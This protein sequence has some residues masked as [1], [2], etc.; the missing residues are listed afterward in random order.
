M[1][2]FEDKVVIVTGGN[3][4]IGLATAKM[5]ADEGAKVAITGRSSDKLS[6][7]KSEIGQE[8][9][10]DSVDITSVTE[11]EAFVE[12]VAREHGRID[13][14]VASA[15]GVE[16]RP[17]E[18][19]DESRFDQDLDRNFK[20]AYFTAQRALPHMTQGGSF[21]FLGSAAGSKG[22]EGMT[23]YGPSK[24]AL[25]GLVRSLASELAPKNIRANVVSPGPIPTPG[26]DRLGLPAEQLEAVKDQ[27]VSEVPLSRMGT[28]EDIA[29]AITFLASE[30]A[31]YITGVEL[32]V[33]GGH[34]QV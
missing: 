14:V 11:I 32:G 13:V 8:T 26:M 21:V 6:A 25:R 10:A 7:A 2:R 28:V 23:V 15:G 12:K 27:F 1:K 3:S 5:F 24:A 4:G 34:A 22:F 20:G 16:V 31:A 33:D 19:M 18:I 17:F 9:I 30:Q 29:N